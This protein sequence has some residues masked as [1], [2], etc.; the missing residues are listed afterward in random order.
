[1][2]GRSE[3][4]MKA[5]R[6]SGT[7]PFGSQRQPFS[8]DVPAANADAATEKVYSTLGSRHRI[9]RRKIAID[10]VGEIDPRTSTEPAVLSTFREEIA[11]KGGTIAPVA[12]EE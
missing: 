2:D 10:S 7:A 6:V 8:Y 1:M 4:P 9:M 5:Y 12:E 11:A 3:G